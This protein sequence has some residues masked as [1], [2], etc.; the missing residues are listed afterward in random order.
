MIYLRG[1]SKA[2]APGEE[3]LSDQERARL[4]DI[5]RQ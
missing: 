1:R 4:D 5:L 3:P 2:T